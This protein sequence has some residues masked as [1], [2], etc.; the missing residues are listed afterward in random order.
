M[1]K[2]IKNKFSEAQMLAAERQI[3]ESQKAVDYFVTEY[4]IEEFLFKYQHGLQN[5]TNEIFIPAYHRGFVWDKK[6][7]IA[8]IE[9]VLLGLPITPIVVAPDATLSERFE[10]VDGVQRLKTLEAFVNNELM[11]NHLKKLTLLN[12]FRFQDLPLSRQRGFKK[13]ILRC[14]ELSDKTDFETRM[15]L[16]GRINQK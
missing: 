3:M 2:G 5:E 15:D 14:V 12:G 10:L 7:Q 16:F 8:F 9:S 4:S 6:K 1:N 11:L 13:R